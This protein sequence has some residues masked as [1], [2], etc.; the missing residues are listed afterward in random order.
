MTVS[1][2]GVLVLL[3][4]ASVMALPHQLQQR[5]PEPEPFDESTCTMLELNTLKHPDD[6]P[7]ALPPI[8]S[9]SNIGMELTVRDHLLFEVQTCSQV[10]VVL[11]STASPLEIPGYRLEITG[12]EVTLGEIQDETTYVSFET[13]TEA[14]VTM[15]CETYQKFFLRWS[16][17]YVKFGVGWNYQNDDDV[18]LSLNVDTLDEIRYGGVGG[19]ISDGN[20]RICQDPSMT[21]PKCGK[22]DI[23]IAIDISMSMTP[24]MLTD[25]AAGFVKH[26]VKRL[27]IGPDDTEI[28]LVTF[29]RDSKIEFKFG[30]KTSA[31]DII[32]QT[33]EAVKI[34]DWGT[35]I[36]CAMEDAKNVLY[37]PANGARADVDNIFILISDGINNDIDGRSVNGPTLDA[38]NML[39]SRIEVYTLGIP[40][41]GHMG[42]NTALLQA[43]SYNENTH[44]FTVV[45]ENTL[46]DAIKAIRTRL[47]CFTEDR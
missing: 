28:A 4:L 11:T 24:D 41:T 27:I 19:T 22:A 38:I 9:M 10:V 37:D 1:A 39:D 17:N 43:V 5:D 30:E 29:K 13:T 6:P 3:G 40:G 15:D 31:D 26:L 21:I 45:D 2:G 33:F 25:Y 32:D 12:S 14:F 16:K 46:D 35:C 7:P 34:R 36:G 18:K 44:Y 47:N 23:S 8:G 42:L 20:W